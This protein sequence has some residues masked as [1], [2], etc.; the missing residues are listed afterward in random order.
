MDIA[1]CFWSLDTLNYD[2]IAGPHGRCPAVATALKKCR[3]NSIVFVYAGDG[4]S[5]SIGLLETTYAA[6]RDVPI[7]M[8]VANNAVFGMTGGQLSPATTL[9][10]QKTTSSPAGRYP[11]KHGSPVDMMKVFRQY[12]IQFAARGALFG[13][14]E[15]AK[16][17][18]YIKKGFQNQAQQKGFSIIEILSPCPTNWGLRPV[19][20]NEMIR[21]E[22]VPFFPLGIAVEREENAS[23]KS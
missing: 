4:A 2:G 14:A 20:A 16:T 22:L 15:I 19:K 7:T 8:I 5:Y 18:S 13:P 21:N 6:L 1:C 17:K 9:P 11:E 3:N 23:W 12:D 10:G